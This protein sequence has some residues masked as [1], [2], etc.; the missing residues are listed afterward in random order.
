MHNLVFSEQSEVQLLVESL[1]KSTILNYIRNLVV[2]C[3]NCKIQFWE[4]VNI[5][6]TD[7]KINWNNTVLHNINVDLRRLR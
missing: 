2:E 1:K 4:I 7:C 5:E 3:K 6:V